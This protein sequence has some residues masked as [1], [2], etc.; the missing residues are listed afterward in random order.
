MCL[1]VAV[2]QLFGI[3]CSS[4]NITFVTRRGHEIDVCLAG[5]S[6]TICIF[7]AGAEGYGDIP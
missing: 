3:T 4:Q 5:E 7:S 1:S 6:W 2:D